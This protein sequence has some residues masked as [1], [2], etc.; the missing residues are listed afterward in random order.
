MGS[1]H[2]REP[3]TPTLVAAWC[4]EWLGVEPTDVLFRQE[5][6]SHVLGLRLADGSAV[7]LNVIL[8]IALLVSI[9]AS[10]FNPL[11]VTA[12][13]L[14]VIIMGVFAI[15]VFGLV[16]GEDVAERALRAVARKI[17]F[18]DDP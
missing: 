3:P 7:V 14:G 13:I 11:Y 17:R 18:L 1:A 9:P 8:W 12:A 10:G 5:H 6:L 2:E 15:I 4:G 16:K